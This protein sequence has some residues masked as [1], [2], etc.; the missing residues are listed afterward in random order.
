MTPSPTGTFLR[1]QPRVARL[2]RSIIYVGIALLCAVV[3]V[4]VWRV[5]ENS[6]AAASTKQREPAKYRPASATAAELMN[7]RAKA[8]QVAPLA[9][10][11]QRERQEQLLQQAGMRP[12]KAPAAMMASN[13]AQP[14]QY[15][16]QQQMQPYQQ[17]TAPREATPQEKAQ[18]D[19]YKAAQ[20][21]LAAPAAVKGWTGPGTVA[22]ATVA[23]QGAKAAA[24]GDGQDDKEAFVRQAARDTSTV[25]KPA[26]S[27]YLIAVGN[28]IPAT[29]ASH[30][31]SDLPGS[32]RA[33]VRVNVRDSATGQYIL[34]PQG[35]WIVGHYSSRIAYGQGRVQQVWNEIV[36]PDAS[37][38]DLG[39]MEGQDGQGR[40][41][42]HDKVNNHYGRLFGTAFLTSVF[43]AAGALSQS[44]RGNVLGYPSYTETASSAASQQMSQE[45]VEITRKNQSIQPTI[46]IRPGAAFNIFVEKN[47]TFSGPYKAMPPESVNEAKR[48]RR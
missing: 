32:L 3:V 44:H 40:G 46:E 48:E 2:R 1:P 38:I 19:A 45:A 20:T 6:T 4:V 27:R 28:V 33:Q 10:G 41:G 43:Y 31:N 35:S 8:Q 42:L 36:F 21:A 34:I 25:R 23:Q 26:E 16:A 12:A 15:Y 17:A 30:L 5:G 9:P 14:Q 18:A 29:L 11:F 24:S 47:M 7:H 37:S 13:Y 39:G 22:Q